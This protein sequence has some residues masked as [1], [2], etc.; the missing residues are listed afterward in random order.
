MTN[1]ATLTAEEYGQAE[2]LFGAI[3]NG[4]R[5]ICRQWNMIRRSYF[6]LKSADKVK[7]RREIKLTAGIRLF[8]IRWPF[9]L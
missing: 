8:I 3:A 1:M 7:L 2:N 6:S 4:F 5:D 9:L